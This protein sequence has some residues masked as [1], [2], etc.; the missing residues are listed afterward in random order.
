LAVSSE[1][2][3]GRASWR[4][5]PALLDSAL[6][7]AERLRPAAGYWPALPPDTTPDDPAAPAHPPPRR[8]TTN[9]STTVWMLSRQ[10]RRLDPSLVHLSRRPYRFRRGRPIVPPHHVS[11]RC[12]HSPSGSEPTSTAPDRAPAPL[13]LYPSHTCSG[14]PWESSTTTSIR[15]DS[16]F[17]LL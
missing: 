6:R 5:P 16:V 14:C 9:R 3:F 7:R 2:A 15:P 10:L 13:G 4:P 8:R 17:N 12:S 1:K 11:V